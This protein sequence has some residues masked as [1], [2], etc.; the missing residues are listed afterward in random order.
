[1]ALEIVSNKSRSP[2]KTENVQLIP[3]SVSSV[4]ESS[5]VISQSANSDSDRLNSFKGIPSSLL[6]RVCNLFSVLN[7]FLS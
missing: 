1:M 5:K 7:K 3:T 4:V 2:T 6:E